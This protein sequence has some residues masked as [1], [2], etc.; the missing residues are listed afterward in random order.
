MHRIEFYRRGKKRFTFHFGGK[1]GVIPGVSYHKIGEGKTSQ[2]RLPYNPR[3][4]L[5]TP[6]EFIFHP[7]GQQ[8]PESGEIFVLSLY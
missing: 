6:L 8:I 5:F 4:L 2:L 3:A 7:S 1:V